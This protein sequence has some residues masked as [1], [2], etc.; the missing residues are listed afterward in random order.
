MKGY[1]QFCP[2]AKGA[3]VFAERWTPLVL[4]ELL[5]GSTHFS[6]LH[7]GVPLMSRSLLS[8]RLKQLEQIGVV[9]R[10]HGPQGPQYHLTPAGRDFAPIVRRLGEWGQRWFRSRYVRDELD[11]TLLMWDMRRCIKVDAFPA[12]RTCVQRFFRSAGVEAYLV[13][14]LRRRGGR[15]LSRQPGV[16]GGSLCCDRPADHDARIH[17]RSCVEKRHCFRPDR[18][19]RPPGAAPV[20]RALA[21]DERVR[22]YRRRQAPGGSRPQS[23][24]IR[25]AARCCA[26]GLNASARPMGTDPG[27]AGATRCMTP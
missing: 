2:V 24:S 7:R 6:D 25:T 26:F 1:G 15:P 9:E 16:R 27:L 3:E 10:K 12:G 19:R 13:A 23:G 4:R 22:P 11:V 8:L 21:R 14:G 5:C 17:G 20:L 18:A